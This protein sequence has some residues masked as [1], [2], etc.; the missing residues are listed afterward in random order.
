MMMKKIMW[1]RIK[2]VAR[3][4]REKQWNRKTENYGTPLGTLVLSILN[5]KLSYFLV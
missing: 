1:R 5:I 2:E 3:R 4:G